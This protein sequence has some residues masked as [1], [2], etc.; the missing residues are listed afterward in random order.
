MGIVLVTGSAGL[1]GSQ[2]SRFFADKGFVVIG[3]DNDMRRYFFGDAASTE[4][5]R[6][7]L[8]RDLQGDYIHYH[9]DIR[10][11]AAMEELFKDHEFSCIIHAAAQPSHDWAV[12]DP[13]T[14]FAVNAQGTLVLL[15]MYRKYCPQAVFIF[16][17]T[18][19]VYGDRPNALPLVELDTRYELPQDHA[20]YRGIDESMSVDASTHS[21]FGV[22]KAAADLM[23]Q[24]YGRYFGLKT[25]VFRG[26]CLTGPAHSATRMHG[27][28]A[29]LVAC[30]KTG[31]PY[32]IFGY[33]GK[34][35][36]DNI[37]SYD[38][39]NMFWHFYQNPRCGEVYN[40]GGSRHSNISMKEA[41]A[42][43]EELLGEQAAVE[44][45]ESHRT[46]DHIWYISDVS[47]FQ[48]HYP[49]WHYTYD[50]DRILEEM[51][52]HVR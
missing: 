34:Q 17:S 50:I 2:A 24:E 12:Q 33:M 31:T 1:I 40:V 13:F 38:L 7:E 21:L 20:F 48:S 6:Q 5:N 47:K 35:V 25:G 36:R 30:V 4:W 41:I 51:C 37:H 29:Y 43:I 9:A 18:N 42:K 49:E 26:G 46:G 22:S 52:M 32:T 11:T 39:V 28:L 23:V 8:S 44:Y 45:S 10:D 3:V 27:F 14:D 15:E 19:K 16:T